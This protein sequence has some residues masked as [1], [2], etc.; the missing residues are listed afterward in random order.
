MF[1]RI[2]SSALIGL[3]TFPALCQTWTLE[4]CVHYALKNSAEVKK[5]SYSIERE[6]LT[7]QEGKWAFIPKLS[8]SSSYTM[9]TG[10]VLDPTTY[11]FVSTKP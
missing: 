10:R 3:L 8:V 11:Q 2:I 4:D 7:L 1:R 5:Q 6:K 9:S